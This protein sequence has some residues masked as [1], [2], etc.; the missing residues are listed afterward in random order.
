MAEI[1]ASQSIVEV[2]DFGLQLAT[3]LQSFVEV[4]R[5]AKHGL[6]E[7]VSD[8][9]S[10]VSALKQLQDFLDA[11]DKA[12]NVL[13]K[14]VFTSEGRREIKTMTA[15]CARLYTTLV[16]LLRKAGSSTE[17]G[18]GKGKEKVTFSSVGSKMLNVSNLNPDIMNWDWL[19][20]RIHRC[21]EQLGWLKISLLLMLRLA[22]L[23]RFQLGYVLRQ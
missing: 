8:V 6:L 13:E 4:C 2:I 10:T 11:D 23:A 20:Q 5:K 17:K 19:E 15:Q 21:Q 12:Q 3:L 22:S 18:K 7:V 16:V 9:N 1:E 14:Q